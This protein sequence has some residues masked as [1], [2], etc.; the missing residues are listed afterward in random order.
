M[1]QVKHLGP[2]SLR[3]SESVLRCGEDVVALG[4]RDVCLIATPKPLCDSEVSIDE[5]VIRA[6]ARVTLR[7]LEL[8]LYCH[9]WSLLFFEFPAVCD[10][11]IGALSEQIR[12]YVLAL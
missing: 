1:K 8:D 12:F 3:D 2:D 5:V 7:L 4:T 10:I 11:L 9:M 6:N